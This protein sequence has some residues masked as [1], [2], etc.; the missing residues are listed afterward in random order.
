MFNLLQ[1]SKSKPNSKEKQSLGDIRHSKAQK[2]KRNYYKNIIIPSR[3]AQKHKDVDLLGQEVINTLKTKV[4]FHQNL[5]EILIGSTVFFKYTGSNIYITITTKKGDVLNT[6]S[7]GFFEGLR[8]RK[9]KTTVFVSKQLGVLLAIRLYKLNARESIFIPF[10][11][12]RKARTLL[13][14]L[15]QGL[16]VIKPLKFVRIYIKINVMRNGVRLRKAPR[17]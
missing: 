10:L 15:L 7:S 8:T 5:T 12:N 14:F 3:I 9:E 2:R 16:R 1:Q 6:Y 17:K 11:N 4:K 13:R